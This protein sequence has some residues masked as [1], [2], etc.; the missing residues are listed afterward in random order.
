MSKTIHNTGEN[1]SLSS[2]QEYLISNKKKG[3]N[4]MYWQKISTIKYWTLGDKWVVDTCQY[5]MVWSEISSLRRKNKE[6]PPW[7]ITSLWNRHVLEQQ[8]CPEAKRS[9]VSQFLL[10][11]NETTITGARY[12]KKVLQR[13]KKWEINFNLRFS[14][15]WYKYDVDKYWFYLG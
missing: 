5:Q 7:E 2:F 15:P 8:R 13:E 1:K 9:G 6:T 3:K 14:G 4:K 12:E 10:V 11:T